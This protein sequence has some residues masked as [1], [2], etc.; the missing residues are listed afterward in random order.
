MAI[1][2]EGIS[3]LVEKHPA[4]HISS[5]STELLKTRRDKLKPIGIQLYTLRKEVYPPGADLPGVLKTVADIGYKG[6]EF[7]GLHGNDPKAIKKIM[8]DLGLVC[9]SS[10]TAMP[11][12]GNVNQ[13]ADTEAALG[14]KRVIS[15]FG[16]NDLQTLDGVK[17]AAEK[18]QKAAELLKPYG[19]SFGF[20]NHWWEF[21]PMDGQYVYDILM[22]EA[23]DVFSELDTYWCAFGKSSPVMCTRA[24]ASRIPL[25]HVKD[26]ML[27]EGKHVHTAVGSGKMNF[28]AILKAADENVLDW[29]IVELD[30][31]ETDMLQ[32][33]KDSYNYLVSSGLGQGN[34]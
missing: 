28:L 31:C 22:A 33:V 2:R 14:N 20:H 12:E 23:P 16:P 10:H 4:D 19:M 9:T 29:L 27:E 30:A 17:A 6:V 1:R 26:G 3:V 34:K 5:P 25:F 24:Y 18:M 13:I 7:A 15:G 11:D 8:D 21:A 32:A